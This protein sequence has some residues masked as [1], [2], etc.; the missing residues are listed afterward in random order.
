MAQKE[1]ENKAI[2][3]IRI[4]DGLKKFTDS[5]LKLSQKNG[6]IMK[7]Q[8]IVVNELPD[9]LEVDRE[10]QFSSKYS[11]HHCLYCG[12]FFITCLILGEC[13]MK[14]AVSRAKTTIQ[15]MNCSS[16]SADGHTPV[17]Y[18]APPPY[19]PYYGASTS[20]SHRS[21]LPSTS[22][23]PH[24]PDMNVN[25]NSWWQQINPGRRLIDH[26]GCSDQP[27][28]YVCGKCS[29]QMISDHK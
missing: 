23:P 11:F 13:K 14:S 8:K 4:K 19:S 17:E 28:L 27:T 7:A 5:Y 21:S 25:L 16:E 12:Q 26:S 18:D 3:L 2:K 1:K 22:S 29:A 9:E 24:R 10:V 15:A 6:V 20:N